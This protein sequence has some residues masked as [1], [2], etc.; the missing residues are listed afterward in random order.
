MSAGGGAAVGMRV[1]CEGAE[2]EM[3]RHLAPDMVALHGQ[4]HPLRGWEGPPARR[5]DGSAGRWHLPT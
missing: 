2:A 1:G 4:A 5:K 3:P